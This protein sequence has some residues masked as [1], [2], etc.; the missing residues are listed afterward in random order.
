LQQLHKLDLELNQLIH[1]LE[2]DNL[3]AV[4]AWL[5]AA[6]R[7]H[8]SYLNHRWREPGQNQLDDVKE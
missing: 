4:S 6:W 8:D 3:S 5:Q 2:N 1:A 7:H